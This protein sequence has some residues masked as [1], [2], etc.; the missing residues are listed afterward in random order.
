MSRT[1]PAPLLAH[2]GGS[3]LTLTTLVKITRNDGQIL[4][5]SALDRDLTFQGV[6]YH[7]ADGADMTAIRTSQGVGVDNLD[8]QGI[9][10]SSF[11]R[12]ADLLAGLFDSAQ[13]E[14]FQVNWAESP[15]VS[16]IVLCTGLIGNVTYHDGGYTAEIRALSSRLT[17]QIGEQTSAT[18]RVFQ[19]GDGRCKIKLGSVALSAVTQA[20]PA[21]V[22]TLTAHGRAVGDPVWFQDVGGMTG[23]SGQLLVV[24]A[25][26]NST[27]FTVND[28]SGNPFSTTL[29]GAYT[30][31]GTIGYQFVRT[32]LSVDGPPLASTLDCPQRIIFSSDNNPVSFYSYGMVTFLTGLNTGISREI[33]SNPK[34]IGGQADLRLQ[35]AFP[36]TVAAGDTARLEAGCDRTLGVCNSRFSNVINYRGENLIPGIDSLFLHGRG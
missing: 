3:L 16:K 21:Q 1:V 11:I 34:P 28:T 31:G 27:Q 36:F 19:L 26:I 23:L 15:L 24:R 32:V 7:S 17:Q 33:K 13:V 9:L 6:V 20:S 22:T 35:E 2:I 18:C 12:D 8:V 14:I 30:S 5:L 4:G 29:F 25:V 10:S